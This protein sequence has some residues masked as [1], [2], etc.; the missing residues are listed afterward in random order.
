M[1]RGICRMNKFK[2]DNL[3]LD[4]QQ[5]VNLYNS[6]LNLK[7]EIYVSSDR[8]LVDDLEWRYVENMQSVMEE[9]KQ[10]GNIKSYTYIHIGDQTIKFTFEC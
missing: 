6:D 8:C 10:N 2:I 7:N 5:L 1:I 3:S 9:L 4:A